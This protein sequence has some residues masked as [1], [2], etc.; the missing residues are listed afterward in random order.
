M[1]I[2]NNGFTMVELLAVISILGILVGISIAGIQG[3]LK[4]SKT[5]YLDNQNKMVVLAGKAY[6]NDYRSR[7][8]K[9]MGPVSE[10]SLQTLI[11]LKYIDPIKDADGNLCDLGKDSKVYVQKV[12]E[13]EYKYWAYLSCNG[14]SSGTH[15]EHPPTVLLTPEK[16]NGTSKVPVNIVLTA[17]DDTEVLSYHYIIYKDGYEYK[18]VSKRYQKPVHIRLVENGEYTIKAF[19]YDVFGNRTDTRGGVYSV[20]IADPD[21]SLFEVSATG[22]NSWQNQNIVVTVKSTSPTIETW[23][24]VDQYTDTVTDRIQNKNLIKKSSS[25][26][27]IF[28]LKDNGSHELQLKGY[29]SAGKSCTKKLSTYYIDKEKPT[30]PNLSGNPGWTK[31]NFSLTATTTEKYSGVSHWEYSY[32]QVTWT[33]YADSSKDTFVTTPFSEEKNQD[34]YIRVVDKAGNISSVSSSKIQIDKTP[35][36]CVSSGAGTYSFLTFVSGSCSD[37]GSGCTKPSII[38]PVSASGSYSPGT[39]YDNAGNATVCP[40]QNVVIHSI[41]LI[42]PVEPVEPEKPKKTVSIDTSSVVKWQMDTERKECSSAQVQCKVM[43]GSLDTNKQKGICADKYCTNNNPKNLKVKAGNYLKIYN[44]SSGC[45]KKGGYVA[46]VVGRMLTNVSGSSVTLDLFIAQGS[47]TYMYNSYYLDLVIQK[48]GASKPFDTIALKKKQNDDWGGGHVY[49]NNKAFKHSFTCDEA[50]TYTIQ[51]VGNTTD[52]GFKMDFG[53]IKV[54][55][56]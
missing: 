21:C 29:N 36:T 5:S 26:K 40:T 31:Q 10:V 15:E 18:S 24:L 20:F 17:K 39:F 38:I 37:S 43:C 47:Q 32:D 2:K 19:V 46:N 42:D 54:T 14:K 12:T 13:E 51:T 30:L 52:P 45:F 4:R 48:S 28:I 41:S 6:Y 9:V 16:T 33:E 23:S 35:P 25:S 50:G 55:C 34:I 22:G 8:P 7:L 11:D 27:K 49:D 53:T 1:K 3:V 44:Q 56:S